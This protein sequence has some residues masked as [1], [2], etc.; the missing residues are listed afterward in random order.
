MSDAT[1]GKGST[2]IVLGI[3]GG[4]STGKSTVANYLAQAHA[5]P[6]LDADVLARAV[7]APGSAILERIQVHF[8][9]NVMDSDGRLRR[10]ALAAIIFNKPE[11]RRWLESEIHP[12]VREQLITQAQALFETHD[13]IVMVIPLLFE[14][15]MTDLVDQI[16]VVA[17][18]PELQL[19]RLM[20]R[21]Q[22]TLDQA[23]ARIDSQMPLSEK[24]K[25]ADVVL[26]NNGTHEELI[27]QIDQ[28]WRQLS[29]V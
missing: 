6:I 11:E 13:W 27:A 22:L 16:W 10:G 3:T 26:D 19:K 29:Q 17:L 1:K 2:K 15:E 7:V 5:V 4:I 25:R 14:A 28:A 18:E 21:N 8:G 9:D 12:V 20:A 23:Q 24:I